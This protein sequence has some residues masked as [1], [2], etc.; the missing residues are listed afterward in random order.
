MSLIKTAQ[1]ISS[2]SESDKAF[3]SHYQQMLGLSSIAESVEEFSTQITPRDYEEWIR[4]AKEIADEQGKDLSQEDTF[5]DIVWEILDN[6][7]KLTA[8]G[9]DEITKAHLVT[10]LWHAFNTNRSHEQ[11]S[12]RQ[13][14]VEDEE[15]SSKKVDGKVS[16][17]V[18]FLSSILSNPALKKVYTAGISVGKEALSNADKAPAKAPYV[19]GTLRAK[20][21]KLGYKQG[22]SK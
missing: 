14:G 13:S 6:D 1:I 22:F 11:F 5:H 18:E 17:H 19:Q 7:P 12:S 2:L 4:I 10:T 15:S 3:Y 9:D 8:T 16:N 21:W 20:V